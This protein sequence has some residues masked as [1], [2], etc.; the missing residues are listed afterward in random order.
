MALFSS[1]EETLVGRGEI[2]AYSISGAGQNLSYALV[3]GYLMYFYINVFH[4]DARAVG[5]M[6]FVEGIWDII[7]N[8]LCGM[9]IDRTRTKQGKLL[10]Y[11]RKGTA[12]LALFTVLLFAG[13]YIIKNVSPLAPSKLVYMFATYFLWEIFYTVTDVAYWGLSAAISPLERDRQRVM[14]ANNIAVNV[15]ASLPAFTVPLLLDYSAQAGARISTRGIFMLLGLTAGIVGIGLFS[16]SGFLVKERIEQSADGSHFRESAREL[17]YNK[18]LRIIV[19]SGLLQSLTGIGG[20]F[21]T[22]YLIDVLGYAGLSLLINIPSVITWAFSY[23]L[24]PVI[25]RHFNSRQISIISRL[26]YGALWLLTF[27]VGL[28]YYKSA[29]VMVPL[30]MVNTALLGLINAPAG[31]VQ[32]EMLADATD[33]S[34]WRTGKRSEGVS[35]SLRITTVKIGGTVVQAAAS[36]LLWAIGYVTS[37]DNARVI[38]SDAVQFRIFLFV[39]LIPAIMYMLSA[40]PYLFYDLTGKE[41][42]KMREEL[43]ERRNSAGK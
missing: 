18:G 11:L 17:I 20:V 4:I 16:L 39:S 36:G 23:M 15:G 3:T 33:Y 5:L 9:I 30:L 41:L 27:S 12:P 2:A 24:I 13:P 28:K 8:P 34:E 1:K 38:Q 26:I 21:I 22:Y 25:R 43:T 35:F 40:V 10:P 14:T 32:N 6:L 42:Q 7:N 31:I 19:I 37:P 29:V